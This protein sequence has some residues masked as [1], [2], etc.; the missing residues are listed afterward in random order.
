MPRP[1]RSSARAWTHPT[2]TC[3]SKAGQAGQRLK[4]CKINK[5]INKQS[6]HLNYPVLQ[7]AAM[8]GLVTWWLL[9]VRNDILIKYRVVNSV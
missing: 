2:L 3:S 6:I 5:N 4:V 7:L 8:F 9:F 1:P